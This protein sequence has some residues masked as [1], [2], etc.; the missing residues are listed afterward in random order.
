MN[1]S[2]GVIRSLSPV[3][4]A[5]GRPMRG[6]DAH[7]APADA[8]A[9]LDSAPIVI[10]E[11]QGADAD[12]AA[13]AVPPVIQ[14]TD[15]LYAAEFDGVKFDDSGVAVPSD[16]AKPAEPEAT[17]EG[18]AAPEGAAATPPV[19][20]K[21]PAEIALEQRVATA[22][23]AAADARREADTLKAQL[24]KPPTPEAEQEE[25]STDSRPDPDKYEFGEADSKYI[26]D[27]GKWAA[28]TRFDER[29][30]ARDQ[31]ASADADYAE[32]EATWTGAVAQ[33][34]IAEQYPDF[35]EKVVAGATAGAWACS[36]VMTVTIKSSEV[37]PHMAYELASN[38]AEADRIAKLPPMEQVRE[39]GRIEGK[40]LY[41]ASQREAA[42]Q[43]TVKPKSVPNV[44]KAP[45]PPEARVRGSGGKFTAELDSTYDR[46]LK[47]F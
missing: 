37:G 46:M 44:S 1:N 23:A 28:D 27:L 2:P 29:M 30:A 25:T 34:E 36:P 45:P 12:D 5:M 19:D 17:P 10:E 40:Y 35:N 6:P 18:E 20:S 42:P 26:I 7:P 31:K 8:P 11:A 15:D 13:P 47:E 9:A 33:P 21:T 16:K 41:Q 32:M 22:E 24:P 3:E 14:S 4:A 43:G 38:A 39:L